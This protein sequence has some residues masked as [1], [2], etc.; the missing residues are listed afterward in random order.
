MFLPTN[1]CHDRQALYLVW[2]GFLSISAFVFLVASVPLWLR[3]RR[4][5]RE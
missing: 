5:R 2:P 3:S 1:Y 4:E